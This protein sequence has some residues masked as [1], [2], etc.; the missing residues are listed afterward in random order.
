MARTTELSTDS[1]KDA[2]RKESGILMLYATRIF[3]GSE[4]VAQAA[5]C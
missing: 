4:E 5:K 3:E 2:F 1:T